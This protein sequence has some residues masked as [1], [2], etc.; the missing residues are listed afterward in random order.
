MWSEFSMKIGKNIT[1]IG[2]LITAIMV[3]CSED[4]LFHYI[5]KPDEQVMT[6]DTLPEIHRLLINDDLNVKLFSDTINAL[7]IKA[8]KILHKNITYEIINDSL[9]LRNNNP[10]NWASYHDSVFIEFHVTN[11]LNRIESHGT[12]N[13]TCND[14]I[15]FQNILLYAFNGA[16]CFNLIVNT[17]NI[18]IVSHSFSTTFY[19]IFGISNTLR[20]RTRGMGNIDCI[21]LNCKNATIFHEGTNNCT[22]NVS[23]EL[24]VKI[25]SIGNVFYKGNP[26]I[27]EK[28][29]KHNGDL[30]HLD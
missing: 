17:D 14:T 10:Y 11:R 19:K 26:A 5:D 22:I 4:G 1:I 27:L 12:G 7:S 15:Y 16:G 24:Y 3:S 9:I 6:I 8:N 30:I 25:W 21:D 20:T 13:I 2:I 18:S 29:L 23:N 28:E